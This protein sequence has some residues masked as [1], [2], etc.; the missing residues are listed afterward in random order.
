MDEV[1]NTLMEA[2]GVPNE[3]TPQEPAVEA[4][5][6]QEKPQA[7]APQMPQFDPNLF[8]GALDNVH[9]RLDELQQPQAQPEP[10]PTEEDMIL[11]DV[12]Q[13]L[14]LDKVQEENSA[15]K[16]TLEQMQQQQQQTQQFMQQQQIEQTQNS[17]LQKYDG[18]SKDMVYGK[19]QEIAQTH[20]EDFATSMNNPQGWEFL[21]STQLQQPQSSP[22]P[23]VSTEAS[24]ND[25]LSSAS[26]RV[27]KGKPQ[28]GDIGD[29][30]A[31]MA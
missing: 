13:K 28:A 17:I 31:S 10:Q 4:Q 7:E 20:G 1:E 27:A 29:L 2:A 24:G 22:D 18:I 30:L 21:I 3:Q 11:K 26:E 5:A 25:F 9:S 15:L 12:A 23:I 14:G 16:Q 8:V 19:L 6:P